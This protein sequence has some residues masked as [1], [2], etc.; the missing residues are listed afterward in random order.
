MNV[1]FVHGMGR[2]SLSWATTLIR[3]R[4]RGIKT[5]VF[6]YSV[7]LQD[8]SAIVRSLVPVLVTLSKRGEYVLVGHSLGGVLLRAALH[9]MPL[10]AAM[11]KRLF[12]LGSPVV[13]SRLARQLSRSMLFRAVTRDC[14]R[15][16]GSEERMSS[17]PGT[18]VHTVAIAGTRGVHGR[19]SPF[20]SEPNDGIVSLG[21]VSTGDF[22]EVIRVPV[23][24]T[25]LP[26][27]KRVAEIMLER[28][29]GKEH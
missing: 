14:G 29:L 17:I 9:E 21:E 24:H 23:V 26:S 18:A 12:L 11:P 8:F 27:S 6:G 2:S 28:I 16:L 19:L 10:G 5:F 22:A 25:L 7:A 3:F 20:G 1:L 13:S 15:L 4:S